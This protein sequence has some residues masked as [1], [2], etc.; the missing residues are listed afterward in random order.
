MQKILHK[1]EVN[2]ARYM[3]LNPSIIASKGPNAEVYI[4]DYT[5][6]PSQPKEGGDFRPDLTLAGHDE[7]VLSPSH[8]PILQLYHISFLLPSYSFT[9]DLPSVPS[10]PHGPLFECTSFLTIFTQG[11]GLS[12]CPHMEGR[13]LSGSEDGLICTWDVQA[14]SRTPNTTPNTTNQ[15]MNPDARLERMREWAHIHVCN[16]CVKFGINPTLSKADRRLP[17]LSC[18]LILSPKP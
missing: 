12:W 16:W 1:G 5:R 3:P 6:H 13:L 17:A 8:H 11:Y 14:K 7:Q 9:C 4:F 15:A 2:R 18:R 10:D